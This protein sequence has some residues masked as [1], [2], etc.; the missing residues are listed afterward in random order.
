MV[1][2]CILVY[3]EISGRQA[4]E[5]GVMNMAFTADTFTTN[6]T[7][8]YQCFSEQDKQDLGN[9]T[10]DYSRSFGNNKL[11]LREKWWHIDLIY[12]GRWVVPNKPISEYN[13]YWTIRNMLKT[14]QWK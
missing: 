8:I 9:F 12:V 2:R 14:S 6:I 11:G 3:Q 5:N 13:Q 10:T 7:F 1:G 4:M